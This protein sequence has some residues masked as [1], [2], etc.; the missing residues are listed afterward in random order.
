MKS[1]KNN[2]TLSPPKKKK[3]KKIQQGYSGSIREKLFCEDLRLNKRSGQFE[4]STLI[5]IATCGQ[6]P[7]PFTPTQKNPLTCHSN[8]KR[9]FCTLV[10][11]ML[12]ILEIVQSNL[13]FFFVVATPKHQGFLIRLASGMLVRKTVIYDTGGDAGRRDG[14]GGGGGGYDYDEL[15]RG[16]RASARGGGGGYG[17]NSEDRYGGRAGA[18]YGRSHSPVRR[19]RR[20]DRDSD[21]EIR[22]RVRSKSKRSHVCVA[23]E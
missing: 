16:S 6:T 21:E 7:P 9:K 12:H 3:K 18:G 4:P 14:G 22:Y 20:R 2:L 17:D 23:C 1:G 8:T 19:G 10:S 5:V 15:I 11:Q 13:I